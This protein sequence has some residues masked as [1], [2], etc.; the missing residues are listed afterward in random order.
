[1]EHTPLAYM[2]LESSKVPSSRTCHRDRVVKRRIALLSQGCAEIHNQ[3]DLG[4]DQ[5]I[6]VERFMVR[7]HEYLQQFAIV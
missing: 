3:S 4:R 1:M 5:L 6:I 7:R 2:Q